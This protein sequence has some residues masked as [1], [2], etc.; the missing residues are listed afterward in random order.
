MDWIWFADIDAYYMPL[1]DT[2]ILGEHMPEEL[3]PEHPVVVDA[4]ALP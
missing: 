4:D 3:C 2:L 1:T